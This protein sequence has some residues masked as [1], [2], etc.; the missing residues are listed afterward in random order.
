[1]ESDIIFILVLYH[2]IGSEK[3]ILARCALIIEKLLMNSLFLCEFI[4]NFGVNNL[5]ERIN[6][7]LLGFVFFIGLNQNLPNRRIRKINVFR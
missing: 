3:R 6:I 7:L 4:D 1:M 2:C 5:A